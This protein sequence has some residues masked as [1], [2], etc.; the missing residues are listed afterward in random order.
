MEKK[1]KPGV[2]LGLTKDDKATLY[3][4]ARTAIECAAG[5]KKPPALE[6]KSDILKENR[7][8]F[9]SLHRHGNLR[10]CIGHIHPTKP[11]YKTIQDMAIAAAFQDPRF[12]P[13]STDEIDELDI[14]ISVLTP[15]K[16]IENIQEI[17]IGKHG[18]YIVKNM[19]H[20]LLLPQ[21]ATNYGWNKKTLLEHTCM[22]AGLPQDAWT[23]KDAELYIFSADIF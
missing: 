17:E 8:A 9:V 6:I 1:M 12:E 13:V 5:G 2:D 20:G 7:G 21:V 3:A 11:L 15:M 19:Y 18:L 16:K 4:I 14:E 10:G 23:D 22:K